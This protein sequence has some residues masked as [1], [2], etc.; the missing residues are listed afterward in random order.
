MKLEIQRI[1]P[2]SAVRVGF[3][4][5]IIA[6]FFF[7]LYASFIMKEISSGTIPMNAQ[8]FGALAEMS[9]VMMCL[10]MAMIGS[11][12]YAAAGGLLAMF[13]NLIARLFGGIEFTA[14]SAEQVDGRAQTDDEN[15]ADE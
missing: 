10:V 2:Q 5:G 12:I 14:Q 4:V 3:F 9:P 6:G 7:G 11:L 1:A 8:D 15:T 13:Y